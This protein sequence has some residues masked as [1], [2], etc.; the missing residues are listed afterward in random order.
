MGSGKDIGQVVRS[1]QTLTRG[2]FT[3]VPVL[4]T[5]AC[6]VCFATRSLRRPFS[7]QVAEMSRA[8]RLKRGVKWLASYQ[9]AGNGWVYHHWGICVVVPPHFARPAPAQRLPSSAAAPCCLHRDG[10]LE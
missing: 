10:G 5:L 3:H 8:K 1:D 9:I 7:T 6:Q 2:G 4:H